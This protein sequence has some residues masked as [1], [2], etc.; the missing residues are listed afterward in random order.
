MK[1]LGVFSILTLGFLLGSMGPQSITSAE[2]SE[3]DVYFYWDNVSEKIKGKFISTLL[4]S[5]SGILTAEFRGIP[6]MGRLTRSRGSFQ[7]DPPVKGTWTLRCKEEVFAQGSFASYKLG[8]GRGTGTDNKGR[9]IKIKF[10]E[11]V[12]N[13]KN[14]QNGNIP[15]KIFRPQSKG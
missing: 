2:S 6:C 12:K 5:A 8:A 11:V 15:E 13:F 7:T 4:M 14:K 10:G 1:K 3:Y 9:H